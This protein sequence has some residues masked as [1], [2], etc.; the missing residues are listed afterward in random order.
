M[1]FPKHLYNQIK[2]LLHNY[3]RNLKMSLSKKKGAHVQKLVN[4]ELRS[5]TKQFKTC[6]RI[7]EGLIQ[8]F[9]NNEIF[10]KENFDFLTV[11]K[12]SNIKILKK[13]GKN[14]TIQNKY[15]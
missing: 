4:L 6:T 11:K 9:K 8:S 3:C 13:I 1:N 15:S 7:K 14:F 10:P 12:Y 5:S 2:P